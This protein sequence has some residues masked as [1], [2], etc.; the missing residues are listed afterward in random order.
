MNSDIRSHQ[1]LFGLLPYITKPPGET[2]SSVHCSFIS[3]EEEKHL[4]SCAK[5][6][7]GPEFRAYLS[8]IEWTVTGNT[9]KDST[10]ITI[11]YL[12]K[13]NS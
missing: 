8:G 7:G 6:F 10:M 4:H 12:T 9:V 11:T 5:G 2:G 1:Y 3:S 13:H